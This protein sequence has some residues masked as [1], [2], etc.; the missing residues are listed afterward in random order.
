MPTNNC[1]A[2][3]ARAL[4]LRLVL[5]LPV[6]VAF[7]AFI[8]TAAT[9][10]PASV[11]PLGLIASAS[12]QSSPKKPS[13][14]LTAYEN[15]LNNF[16]SILRQ[17]R[18]QIDGKQPLPNLPGQAIYLARNEM[19]SAHKDLT[20]A[21]PSKIGTPNKFGIPPTYFDAA[22]EPLLDEYLNLFARMQA[23]PAGAQS[24]DTPFKDVADLGIA[25]ARAKGLG[26]ADADAAGRISVGMFFAETNGNQ[27]IGN[28]RSN[29][30]K[31]SF[32]TGVPEDQNGRRKWAAIK[33]RIAAL[34]PAHSL[35]DDREEA[36]AGNM[37]QRFNQ[38]LDRRAER[39][40]EC[41]CRCL[42]AGA[43]DREN[44]AR[45]NRSDEAVR[46][47]PDYPHADPV[48]ATFR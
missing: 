14:A 32:Q 6:C 37:D 31:G 12:A 27:N 19:L 44:A 45:R 13:E 40:H 33:Q 39:S 8:A 22:Q 42:S 4:A 41:T 7:D 28:A 2:G 46:A 21:V 1:F 24:S 43:V 47:H 34:D 5:A 29:K 38:P 48:R 26:S 15:A 16:K 18:T 3:T 30:Y 11:R 23:P 10:V 20:D 35:R 25:I 36:R 9:W 17:R